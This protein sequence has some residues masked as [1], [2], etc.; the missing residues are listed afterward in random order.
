MFRLNTLS[1]LVRP[2][3]TSRRLLS[4]IVNAPGGGLQYNGASYPFHWLRDSCPCPKCVH[5]STRQKL[6][7]TTDLATDVAPAVDGVEYKPDGISI[8]WAEDH[9]SFYPKELLD[10]HASASNVHNFQRDVEPVTWDAEKIKSTPDL[11]IPFKE[12]KT[13]EGLSKAI[14]QITKYGLLFM[15]GVPTDK[16]SNEECA[17]RDVAGVFGEIRETM[18]G[19]T[20]N[21]QNIRNSRNIAY[22]N[23]YLGIHMD[24]Q[25]VFIHCTSI[26]KPTNLH[27]CLGTCNTR[28]DTSSSIVSE[29]E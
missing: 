29:T 25:Y 9:Q 23:L 7:R 27:R 12:M 6:F 10:S 26:Y 3:F 13:K 2:G 18:Y 22:T 15:T 17:L 14:D 11:F 28:R 24:L 1:R 16:T 21:V 20:W 8:K 5:P 4:A 19:R